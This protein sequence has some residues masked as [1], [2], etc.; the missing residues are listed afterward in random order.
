MEKLETAFNQE[1]ILAAKS[2]GIGRL[3]K[4]NPINGGT[5]SNAR[6]LDTE[7]GRYVLRK[8]SGIVQAR[9][10]QSVSQ[11]LKGLNVCPEIM[12]DAAGSGWI[13]GPDGYYN[14]QRWIEPLPNRPMIPDYAELGEKVGL[15]HAALRG[16]RLDAQTDRFD[17][18][19]TWSSFL[20]KQVRTDIEYK[21][22]VRR[23]IRDIEACLTESG[24]STPSVPIHGDLGVWNVVFGSN[25]VRII[26]FGEL[27]Y[28][29][30]LFD[31]AALLASTLDVSD[32]KA[33][34]R[35]AACIRAYRI[36]AEDFEPDALARQIRL[37]NVRGAAAILDKNGLN[38]KTAGYANRVM[39]QHE[40][41]AGLLKNKGG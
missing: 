23:M 39:D 26:D 20:S 15:M 35:L 11:V 4:E 3:M 40:A 6:R 28:G 34:D 1:A 36:H 14:V 9:N 13:S 12:T 38:E 8:L 31:L 41:F 30:P 27:R 18:E 2:Y 21:P 33:E 7:S 37:W 10:E 24:S 17:L 5:T 16:K 29:H 25:G 19:R 32:R 22:L